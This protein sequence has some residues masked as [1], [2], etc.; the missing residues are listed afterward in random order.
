[1]GIFKRGFYN[2]VRN[3]LKSAVLFMVLAIVVCAVGTVLTVNKALSDF[4]AHGADFIIKTDNALLEKDARAI[5]QMEGVEKAVYKF[6]VVTMVSGLKTLPL[7]NGITLGPELENQYKNA[8]TLAGS[9]ECDKN[10]LLIHKDFA[11]LNG[12][13]IG[14]SLEIDGVCLEIIGIHE[15]KSGAPMLPTDMAE[16]TFYTS[17]YNAQRLGGANGTLTNAE[18]YMAKGTDA[19]AFI[20]KVKALPFY[21]E[22]YSL[23]DNTQAKSLGS[24]ATDRVKTLVA[25]M[26]WG[27]ILVSLFALS[28]VTVFRIQ[29][30]LHEA[31]VLL[32]LGVSKG[33]I[34][35]QYLLELA[36]L[37]LPAYVVA[38]YPCR[39]LGEALIKG[40]TDIE[41]VNVRFSDMLT[42]Y[43]VNTAIIMA[44][45]LIASIPLLRLKPWKILAKM[46]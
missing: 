34:I 4:T 23:V 25:L 14:D 41:G 26:V 5:A 32:S 11:A 45:V 29:G 18:F 6:S 27:I 38:Y 2:L 22:S 20:K 42:V 44:A 19:K 40:M 8:V 16:N 13:N 35:A 12:L 9:S 17:L 10:G 30:R 15:E 1:M 33:G 36:Y 24:G 31:G 28:A 3:P 37:A 46:S 43:G 7:N 21:S 39:F